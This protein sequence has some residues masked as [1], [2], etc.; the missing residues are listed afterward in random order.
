MKISPISLLPI[1]HKLIK[2]LLILFLIATFYSQTNI[3][4]ADNGDFSR[5]ATWFSSGPVGI[6]TN[7]PAANTEEFPRR[8]FNYWLPAWKLDF[9]GGGLM[10]SSAML[11]WTPGLLW[12]YYM[13][14]SNVLYTTNISLAPKILIV[15]LM[16]L[17][18]RWVETSGVD[19]TLKTCLLITLAL[20][21]ALML[22]TTDY[23][24]YF[25]SFYFETGSFVFLFC[26]LAALILL[27]KRG[28][29]TLGYVL[30]VALLLL[31]TT[32]KT[33]NIYWP[34]VAIPA[35]FAFRDL[36]ARPARFVPLYIVLLI[37][38]TL[39]GFYVTKQPSM[40]N[41]H[42]TCN[43]FFYGV[44]TFSLE[45][46]KRLA[47]SNLAGAEGCIGHPPFDAIGAECQQKYVDRISVPGTLLVI[48]REP[49][50]LFR[51]MNHVATN[52]QNINLE[53]LGKYA[54]GTA[55]DAQKIPLNFWSKA[56]SM[57]FPKGYALWFTIILYLI[58]FLSSLSRG[59]LP[60]ELSLVGLLTTIALVVDMHISILGDGRQ[61]LV[62]HLFLSNVLFDV[63]SIAA[64]N[65]LMLQLVPFARKRLQNREHREVLNSRT[66]KSSR[67]KLRESP[68][69]PRP[70]KGL[71]R[72]K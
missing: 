59:G 1:S 53:Y 51:M 57:V 38:L 11:L 72:T 13:V 30:C 14:S 34:G 43:R 5:G 64:L 7:W 41:R 12:N 61:E 36:R 27:K 3:G 2:L 35:I 25:N 47:E 63:A 26:F 4:L 55:N 28:P 23:V 66:S 19:R 71:K 8:F 22:S 21:L 31:L 54:R 37:G 48:L 24:A 65:T 67:K 6:E 15:C 58:I 44:L 33:S 56:K 9:P 50:I 62:K 17:I 46:S 18:F 40:Y 29:S 20:P 39:V 10:I 52:M 49:G 42:N 32:S 60:Y 45:P 16:F 70:G 68:H 69:G